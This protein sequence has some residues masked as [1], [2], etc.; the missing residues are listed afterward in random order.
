[1]IKIWKN[2]V[3]KRDILVL[4]LIVLVAILDI[5]LIAFSVRNDA[6]LFWGVIVVGILAWVF[7]F[8]AAIY[9]ID[10]HAHRHSTRSTAELL[11]KLSNKKNKK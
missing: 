3:Y 6:V 9:C 5:L 11:E 8:P 2:C 10:R 7:L 1:M 4:G